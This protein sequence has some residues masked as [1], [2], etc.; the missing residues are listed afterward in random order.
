M[1]ASCR[2]YSQILQLNPLY[3]GL[4][5]LLEKRVDSK[6]GEMIKMIDNKMSSFMKEFKPK[7]V[8]YSDVVGEGI[9]VQDHVQNQ[10][11]MGTESSRPKDQS[12]IEN[13]SVE[14]LNNSLM[15]DQ[16]R[17][18]DNIINL[19]N[20]SP[21]IQPSIFEGST[22]DKLKTGVAVNKSH[23]NEYSENSSSSLLE[24]QDRSEENS[25]GHGSQKKRSV[26]G[27][28]QGDKISIRGVKM[29]GHMHVRKLDPNQISEH[30]RENGFQDVRCIK[31]ESKRPEEYSSLRVSAPIS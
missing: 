11:S 2:H 1:N 23:R 17:L 5:S 3:E 25:R 28:G 15:R 24:S 16:K 27:I 29:L 20:Q 7:R 14:L 18:M 31:M 6:I 8:L 4:A 9:N 21:K 12:N 26:I 10:Y 13:V 30:L 19:S 22:E